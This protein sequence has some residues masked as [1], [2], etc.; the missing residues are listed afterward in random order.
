MQRQLK[1]LSKAKQIKVISS[2]DSILKKFG[3]SKSE[4]FQGWKIDTRGAAFLRCKMKSEEPTGEML[5]N[6]EPQS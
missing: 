5:G 1:E 3:G 2:R 4:D 6:K